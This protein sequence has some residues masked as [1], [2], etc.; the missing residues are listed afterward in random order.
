MFGIPFEVAEAYANVQATWEAQN[1]L[2]T[3]A[4]AARRWMVASFADFTA[5]LESV[6]RVAEALKSYATIQADYLMTLNEYNLN[7][8]KLTRVTGDYK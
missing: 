4:A 8:A 7:V 2:A 5:G 6:A 3:G 1:E